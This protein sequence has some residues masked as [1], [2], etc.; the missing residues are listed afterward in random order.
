[1]RSSSVCLTFFSLMLSM[2]F[3]F[4]CG[5][6]TAG[7]A[8]AVTDEPTELRVE[9]YR[10]E[11]L[12]QALKANTYGSILADEK[13]VIS[14]E[15]TGTVDSVHYR[16]GEAV[17]ADTVLVQLEDGRQRL[18]LNRA[19]ADV[20]RAEVELARAEDSF[21]R[22]QS[23]RAQQLVAEDKYRE[24]K[25]AHDSAKSQYDRALAEQRLAQFD[26]DE[27]RLVS[28]VDGIVEAEF[29][30]P[31]QKVLPGEKLL[32]IQ[33]TRS[34]QVK[35]YVTEQEINL[36]RVGDVADIIAPSNGGS[37]FRATIESMATSADPRTGNF[38]LKLRVSDP[39][40]LLREGMSARVSLKGSRT[41]PVLAVPANAVLGRDR[42]HV[43]FL[44][45]EGV[46]EQKAV[47]LGMVRDNWVP[48]LDGLSPG[49]E[50]I[51]SELPLLGDGTPISVNSLD[52]ARPGH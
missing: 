19:D 10:V 34:L 40:G 9:I 13:V 5:E 51:V 16:E 46:A 25:A 52:N 36:L 42:R 47:V 12:Q 39:D 26:L 44:H 23:L 49:D 45:K 17:L 30:E 41:Q 6:I 20:A 15:T 24:V 3:L 43:V 37:K 27:T 18:R 28:R 4:G 7:K 31:G 8:P 21:E 38:V 32:V 1:M 11:T 33:A 48:V 35:T 29:V 22:Y 2:S 14:A 50:V